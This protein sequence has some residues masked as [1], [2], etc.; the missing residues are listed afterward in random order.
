MKD[1]TI[2]SL[3]KSHQGKRAIFIPSFECFNRTSERP[4]RF[5]RYDRACGSTTKGR[6][7]Q[8]EKKESFSSLW[9]GISS[10]PVKGVPVG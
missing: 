9:P 4:L 6:S 5:G 3:V 10:W 7:G 1:E 8:R 2:Y